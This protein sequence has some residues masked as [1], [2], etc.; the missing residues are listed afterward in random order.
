[1]KPRKQVFF[2]AAITALALGVGLPAFAQVDKVAMRTQG[3]T[4]G[5]CAAI[6]EIY[7]RRLEGIAD[8]K[9]SKSAEAILI[10][11][12]PGTSFQP[13]DIREALDRTDVGVAQFQISARGRVQ[14]EKG[15]RFFVAG[16]DKFSLAPSPNVKIPTDTPVT[17]EAIVNDRT[18]PMELKV[19]SFKPLTAK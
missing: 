4:C 2:M 14:E 19:L 17:D 7:L 9:I 6:S 13:W 11:Y 1:M 15:K 3:L 10:T 5:E 18:D 8:V 16:K 12:K